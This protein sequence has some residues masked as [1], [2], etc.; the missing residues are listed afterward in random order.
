MKVAGYRDLLNQFLVSQEQRPCSGPQL[1]P[2]FL[3]VCLSFMPL[4]LPWGFGEGNPE[5]AAGYKEQ[6]Q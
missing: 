6:K 5:E 2:R 4:L 1:E 3:A